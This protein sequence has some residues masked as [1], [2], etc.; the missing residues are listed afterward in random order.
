[1]EK[2]NFK[3]GPKFGGLTPPLI[4]QFYQKRDLATEHLRQSQFSLFS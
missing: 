4:N 1:M 2:S 3:G